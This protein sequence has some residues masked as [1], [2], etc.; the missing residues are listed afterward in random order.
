MNISQKCA[1]EAKNAYDVLGCIRKN[2]ASR[3]WEA[4][5]ALCSALV[6]PR[7]LF[8]GSEGG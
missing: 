6:K 4:I 2:V 3:L 1:L 8:V 5:P 7:W